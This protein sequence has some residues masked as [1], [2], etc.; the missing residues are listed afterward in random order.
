M[1]YNGLV[2]GGIVGPV[3]SRSV[4]AHGLHET[5][6]SKAIKVTDPKALL[7]EVEHAQLRDTGCLEKTIERL[8]AGSDHLR[9]RANAWATGDIEALRRSEEHTSE[10]QSLMRISYAVFCLQKKN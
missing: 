1:D 6:P 10:L 9:L 8:E 7:A 4:K 3:I 2:Q 5:R